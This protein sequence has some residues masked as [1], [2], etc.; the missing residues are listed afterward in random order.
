MNKSFSG[1]YN[2][3]N[4]VADDYNFIIKSFLLGLYYGDSWFSKIPKNIF[5]ENYKKVV[6][7]LISKMN[8]QVA[9]L[10]EDPNTIIGYSILSQDFQTIHWVYVKERWRK[11][12]VGRSLVPQFPQY[13]SHLTPLGERLLTKF[14]SPPIF[15]P[16][17][18]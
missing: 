12:G 16:F 14:K 9:C 15:N 17:N 6:D 18:F 4:A 8:V 13:V 1:L 11:Y 7:A 5:M 3:R 2:V 10:P